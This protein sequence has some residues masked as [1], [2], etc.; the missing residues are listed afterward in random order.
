MS[1]PS[2]SFTMVEAFARMNGLRSRSVPWQLAEEDPTRLLEDDPAVIYLCRPN[3]PTGAQLD[4]EWVVALLESGGAGGPLV[5]VDEAY[6]DFATD[7]L[8]REAVQSDRMLVVRTCS[9]L[10]GLAG[11]RVGFAVGPPALVS[12]I[13]KSR[14]PYKV[15]QMAERGAIAALR[16]AS[17]W[18]ER[19]VEETVQNR[20]RLA[21]E[22]QMRGLRPL[23]SQANFLLV[24]VAPASAVKLNEAL[25]DR[26]VAV[27]PF[28]DLAGIGEAI[29]VTIGPWEMVEWFLAALD[30]LMP[31][32]EDE[33]AS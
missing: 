1:Y 20:E 4:R 13:E 14:G 25:K 31:G 32:R 26:G 12:E 7:N 3:N 22:L 29:R 6:A 16:D 10:Y 11:L 23:P 19:V 9:K 28:P 17:G 30:D 27:R 2:P 33:D 15:N 8:V 21:G 18:A 5:V 24:P